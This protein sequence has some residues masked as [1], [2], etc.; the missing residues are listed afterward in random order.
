MIFNYKSFNTRTGGWGEKRML[1]ASQGRS[2]TARG[3]VAEFSSRKI[4]VTWGMNVG[5]LLLRRGENS[6]LNILI[7]VVD[8]MSVFLIRYESIDI[9]SYKSTH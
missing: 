9:F 5:G 2:A 4:S 3:G 1:G 6:K 8:K 7:E